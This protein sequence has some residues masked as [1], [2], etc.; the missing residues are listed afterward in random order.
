MGDFYKHVHEISHD[1]VQFLEDF[2]DGKHIPHVACKDIVEDHQ[3]ILRGITDVAII[4]DSYSKTFQ[5]LQAQTEAFKKAGSFTNAVLCKVMGQR[6]RDIIIE[7]LRETQPIEI[8]NPK[9][10]E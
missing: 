6:V 9:D 7:S 8:Q 5:F 4:S 3:E 1:V 10:E 2:V